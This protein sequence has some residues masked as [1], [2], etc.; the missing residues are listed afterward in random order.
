[1]RTLLAIAAGMLRIE[2]KDRSNLF[3]MLL[4]P[5]AFIAMFGPLNRGGEPAPVDLAVIDQDGSFLSRS[6]VEFLEGED[7]ALRVVDVPDSVASGSRSLLLPAGFSDSLASGD[8]VPVR[9]QKARRSDPGEDMAARVSAIKAIARTLT[10]LAE[11]DTTA[12]AETLAVASAG[13]QDRFRAHAARP[14][15]IVTETSVAG[16]GRMLP[17]GFA[18]SAQAMLVLFL[19][20]NTTSAGASH[21]AEEKQSRVLARHATFP[22]GRGRLI[23]G[24]ALGLLVFALAQAAII[25]TVGRLAYGI[26]WGDQPLA[27]LVL[28]LALGLAAAALGIL[29]GGLMR[30]PEQAGALAWIV[31][32]FLGAIGGCWWPLELVPRWMQIVGH[33][34]PAGWAMDALHGLTSFGKG[35]PAVVVPSLVLFAYAAALILIG[36]RVLR[37]SDR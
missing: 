35:A 11:M 15:R 5:G 30:T 3:W 14:D 9:F 20:I 19:L 37:V 29:L 23:A 24:R 12:E 27:M 10:V 26:D 4:M 18:A 17:T 21:I 16:R 28:V 25:L 31:P 32:L 36:A 7:L 13:F 22:I 2:M 8:R 34:S 33:L 1:M 6:F